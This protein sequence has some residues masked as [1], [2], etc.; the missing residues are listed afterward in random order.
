MDDEVKGVSLSPASM[1]DSVTD[2]P[3]YQVVEHV[4]RKE[5]GD[6]AGPSD[7]RDFI[8]GRSTIKH[9]TTIIDALAHQYGVSRGLM[10]RCLSYHGVSFAQSDLVVGKI[11]TLYTEIRGIALGVDDTDTMDRMRTM[12]PYAP[13]IV[14]DTEGWYQMYEP[15]VGDKFKE[16]SEICGVWKY[17]IGQI[18]MIK[19]ILT[20][21]TEAVQGTFPRLLTEIAKWDGWMATRLE[22]LQHLS[23]KNIGGMR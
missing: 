11:L 13:L 1:V 2:W 22:T 5:S 15:W 12:V 17:H 4:K 21:E 10:C 6:G 9:L 16:L 8:H 23:K 19:S 3:L 20:D 18:F 14:D 7:H